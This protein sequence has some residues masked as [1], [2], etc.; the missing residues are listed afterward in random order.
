MIKN[1]KKWIA[2]LVTVTFVWLLQ[3]SVM[4]LAAKGAT[5]KIVSAGSGQGPD[6]IEH[7]G[8]SS[9][10]GGK[11]S[12]LPII[13]IGVGV[14]AVAAVL[15]LVVFKTSYDI[16][17]EWKYSWKRTGNTN[18]DYTDQKILFVGDKKQGTLTYMNLYQGTYTVDGKDMAMIFTIAGDWHISN[19]G[20]FADKNKITGS[21]IRIEHTEL[22]G[23]FE[24]TRVTT[25]A[26]IRA[27]MKE[28]EIPGKIKDK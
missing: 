8:G 18:W 25:T 20:T 1:Q 11:K 21:W 17:G 2:L 28:Q 14:A 16:T 6:F 10:G 23:T 12:I 7:E 19:T 26:S 27:P 3:V 9:S 24:L 13:L 4:P 22:S 15:I 5:E